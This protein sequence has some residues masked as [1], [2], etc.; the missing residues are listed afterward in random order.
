[1][2]HLIRAT[3]IFFFIL[4]S[5]SPA[6]G[7]RQSQ[8]SILGL[9]GQYSSSQVGSHSSNPNG[10]SNDQIST[11]Q[12]P[13]L[14]ISTRL[15]ANNPQWQEILVSFQ[16]NL[17]AEISDTSRLKVYL[18][19]VGNLTID[20]NNRRI[21]GYL[22]ASNF[23]SNLNRFL[24]QTPEASASY[25]LIV[26]YQS[27][28][29]FTTKQGSSSPPPPSVVNPVCNGGIALPASLGDCNDYCIS[30]RRIGNI[31]E[32]TASYNLNRASNYLY[33]DLS[34]T[35]TSGYPLT[36][37]TFEEKYENNN[38]TIPLGIY[39]TSSIRL[40]HTSNSQACFVVSSLLLLNDGSIQGYFIRTINKP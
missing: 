9:V 6:S 37:S 11:S 1:M 18:G 28:S 16:S 30:F 29:I 26:V 27:P 25:D 35:D 20:R 2:I 19:R 5:C 15:L 31:I 34:I 3:I 10:T 38:T 13:N 22:W 12:L 8:D 17:P 7:S 32:T 21:T 4:S 40:D 36:D 33:L 14:Q 39:Q 24:V 23:D